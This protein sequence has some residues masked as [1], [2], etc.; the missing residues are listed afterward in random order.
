MQIGIPK[1]QREL[2]RRVAASPETVKRYAGLGLEPVVE[3]GAGIGAAI[4]DQA[5]TDAGARLVDDPSGVWD[6]DIV[7]KV[8]RPTDEE[9]GRLKS[10]QILVGSLDP[11]M[12]REQVDA[13]AKAGVTA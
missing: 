7:L 12:N 9:M 6:A 13:Y 11:Y 8:Q 5:F 10:G 3:R 4:V 2:E 1:E